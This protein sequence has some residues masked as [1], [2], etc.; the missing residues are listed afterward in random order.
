MARVF[1]NPITL[2]LCEASKNEVFR[3]D[4]LCSPLFV[5][6]KIGR[7]KRLRGCIGTFSPIKLH[8]GLKEYALT[9]ALKDTRF[10]PVSKDELSR[11][12]CAVSLLTNFEDAKDYLDWEVIVVRRNSL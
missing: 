8:N 12:T 2:A 4:S 10:D 11:L 9:S 7:E 1:E 3:R 6:W 5:T